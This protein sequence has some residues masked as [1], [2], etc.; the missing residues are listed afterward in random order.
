MIYE[1]RLIEW[2]DDPAIWAPDS[3][4][5]LDLMVRMPVP[6]VLQAEAGEVRPR[7]L[8]WLAKHKHISPAENA[9]TL[10]FPD[11][12]FSDQHDFLS[13]Q[14]SWAMDNF[15]HVIE[16]IWSREDGITYFGWMPR[17]IA[18]PPPTCHTKS[19][20]RFLGILKVTYGV[21]ELAFA[22]LEQDYGKLRVIGSTPNKNPAAYTLEQISCIDF[23]RFPAE[24]RRSIEVFKGDEG[25][26]RV[27]L[28]SDWNPTV[29]ELKITW[30]KMIPR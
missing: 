5:T 27:S 12:E 11:R 14:S 13:L 28:D 20:H 18:V 19:L 17:R 25:S 23:K 26:I 16:S 22:V 10:R 7:L 8:K 21:D 15:E 9:P 3:S 29:K 4:S 2:V 1:I 6:A 24:L 30:C